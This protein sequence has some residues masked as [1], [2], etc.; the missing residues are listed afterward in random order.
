M[1]KKIFYST[2]LLFLFT[3]SFAWVQKKFFSPVNTIKTIILDA[4]HGGHDS[5]AEGWNGSYEKDI[6]LAVALKTEKAIK[7][8]MP[9]VKVLQTRTTDVFVDLRLRADFANENKGDV[10]VAIHCNSVDGYKTV[11][12]VVDSSEKTRIVKNDMGGKDTIKEKVPVYKNVK[13]PKDAQGMETYVWNPSHN[14]IKKKALKRGIADIE[15]AQIMLDSN[16]KEKYGGGF[17]INSAE[18]VA[19]ASLKTK[20]YFLRSQKLGQ[21]VQDEGTNA[22]RNDRKVKQRGVGIW[23]LQA[24]NMPSV[25]VETGYI[26]HPDEESFLT[27][28]EGQQTMALIIAKALKKYKDELENPTPIE[29]GGKNGQLGLNTTTEAIKP[30]EYRI[31]G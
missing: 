20:K 8:I 21:M 18:F 13:Y 23:V 4:G 29:D 9:N 1:I 14:D 16:Y 27:S 5:G 31:Y 12:Q 2:G 15:N 22:G 7:A 19:K 30:K 24:T 28:A 3:S 26:S 17:D 11:R 6:C 10:F 25:L